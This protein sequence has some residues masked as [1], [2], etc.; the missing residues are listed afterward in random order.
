MSSTNARSGHSAVRTTGAADRVAD[1]LEVLAAAGQPVTVTEV[2]TRI[3]VHKATAS[4]LLGTLAERGL[5]RRVSEGYRLGPRLARLAVDAVTDL[6]VVEVSRPILRELASATGEVA[7]LSLPMGRAVLYLEHV[8]AARGGREEPWVWLRGSPL[9]CSSSGKVFAA[10]GA[11]PDLK[12]AL[13]T[14]LPKRAR[15]TISDPE[16]FMRLLPV[17]RKQGYA[18]SVDELEDGMSSVAVPVLTPTSSVLAAVG[19]AGPSQ[20]LTPGRLRTVSASARS[21]ANVLARRALPLLAEA[22]PMLS[23]DRPPG[24]SA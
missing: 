16:E 14:P 10:Y 20:R 8:A 15:R 11:V 4:R 13:Q 12:D 18:M 1:V 17:V 19:V 3:G 22:S 6:G 21:A 7:Y 2:A 9:H 5:V 23:M 24:R